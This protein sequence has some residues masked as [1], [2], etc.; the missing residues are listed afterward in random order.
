MQPYPGSSPF[1]PRSVKDRDCG[2]RRRHKPLFD[3]IDTTDPAWPITAAILLEMKH[4]GVE[5][6]ALVVQAAVKVAAHR[7]ALIS[8]TMKPPPIPDIYQGT[9]ASTGDSIVYYI[10]RG[11][12]IK[13]GVTA[14]PASR[15]KSL[16]PEE[17]LAVEPGTADLET[18]RKRQFRHLKCRGE[19]FRADPELLEHARQVRSLH[20]DP[21]PSWL[22]VAVPASEHGGTPP[23]LVTCQD[24]MT[25]VEA[26]EFFGIPP[27][28][29]YSWVK[30]GRI[31]AVGTSTRGGM[32]FYID[33]LAALVASSPASPEKPGKY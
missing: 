3:L 25:A 30:R 10:R 12:L 14:S 9:L 1:V 4:A 16:M 24:M 13:I 28:K 7:H 31:T 20:G 21:D 17:I 11:H 6:T 22:A 5:I 19:Y 33:Q 8:A 2:P 29:V 23:L 27:A 26:G 15:F 32:L 18:A